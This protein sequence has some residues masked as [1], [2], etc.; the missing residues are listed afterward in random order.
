VWTAVPKL[1]L[2]RYQAREFVAIR[3]YPRKEHQLNGCDIVCWGISRQDGFYLLAKR[4]IS[5]LSN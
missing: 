3:G 1:A 4:L 5:L 2:R